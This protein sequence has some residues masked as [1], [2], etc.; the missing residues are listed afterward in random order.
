MLHV[1]L[2][3]GLTSCDIALFIMLYY[4]ENS[5]LIHVNSNTTNHTFNGYIQF[6]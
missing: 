6:N 3:L 4:L 2:I 1:H 5:T